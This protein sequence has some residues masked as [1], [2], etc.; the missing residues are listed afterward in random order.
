MRIFRWENIW[1]WTRKRRI[2]KGYGISI[3]IPFRVSK[4]YPRQEENFRWVKK[5]W[6][7]QLPDAQ[8][9]VGKDPCSWLAFSKSAAINAAA[10]EATGDV[11]VIVDA[12]GYIDAEQ[13]LHA[14]Q[15]I[16]RARSRGQRLWYVPYRQFYRLTNHAS[17]KVL[18][19]HPRHPYK[20]PT[21]PLP[22]DIQ[23][24]IG[25]G[26]GHWYGAVIQ[27]VPREA[28]DCVGGWDER[29]RGWGG[30][31]HSA[32]RATD[33]LYWRHKTLPGQVLHLWHPM[34]GKEG[35][36]D[37]VEWKDRLWDEQETPGHNGR[38]AARYSAANGDVRRM[39][40]LVNEKF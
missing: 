24:S 28:F 34:L 9:I 2:H 18:N 29:F 25:S 36:D 10:R 19:S 26:F 20:F 6:R 39:R 27:I 35:V 3:I 38:L 12:D 21:P 37:W 30:E 33:T 8:V 11:L 7:A 4:K 22:C 5:Y 15:E 16:R 1:E 23:N 17:R 14:A 40:A 13:V 32:M 31:D